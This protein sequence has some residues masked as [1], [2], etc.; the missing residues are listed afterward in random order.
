[1]EGAKPRKTKLFVGLLG[2]DTTNLSLRSFFEDLVEVQI[3]KVEISRRSGKRKGFG[4]VIF[5][6]LRLKPL[7]LPSVVCIDG[8]KAFMDTYSDSVTAAWHSV[9]NQALHV[10]ITGIPPKIPEREVIRL[11]EPFGVVL[12]SNFAYSEQSETNPT[13][14]VLLVELIRSPA[15]VDKLEKV[16]GRVPERSINQLWEYRE[17]LSQSQQ[18]CTANLR[19][20]LTISAIGLLFGLWKPLLVEVKPRPNRISVLSKDKHSK[21]ESK[22]KHTSIDSS[23][24]NYRFNIVVPVNLL[25]TNS[26]IQKNKRTSEWG[27]VFFK[28]EGTLPSHQLSYW[29]QAY[30]KRS[31]DHPRSA[32]FN[33][34]TDV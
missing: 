7:C 4:Y 33:I 22:P 29:D 12:V 9:R 31:R 16:W 1:M 20:P 26:F 14:S 2:P 5:E 8:H 19:S 25:L 6:R 21:Y 23:P 30:E 17:L 28:S 27:S 13:T 34:K 3:A 18:V 10:T 32:E 11:L 15:C 24:E